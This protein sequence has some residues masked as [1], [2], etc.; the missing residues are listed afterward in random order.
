VEYL[1]QRIASKILQHPMKQLKH[2]VTLHEEPSALVNMFQRIFGL[3]E[4]T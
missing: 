4:S 3:K 2:E 1:T